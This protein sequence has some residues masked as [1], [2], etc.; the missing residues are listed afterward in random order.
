MAVQNKGE[1]KMK[2]RIISASVAIVLLIITLIFRAS[3]L[4]DIVIGLLSLIASYEILN[5]TNAKNSMPFSIL[6]MIYAFF[7]AFTVRGGFGISF[8]V[9]T[10]IYGILFCGCVLYSFEKI[11]VTTLFTAFAFI[12]SVIFAFTRLIA[13][14]DAKFGMFYFIFIAFCAWG[15]DTGAYFVGCAIGR[16]KLAPVISPKKTIEGLVGGIALNLILCVIYAL[17]YSASVKDVN[18]VSILGLMPVAII[19]SLVSVLGDLFASAVKRFYKIK[20]YGN[21]MPGHGGVLDRFDSI[22]MV[23]VYMTAVMQ[24]F[25]LVK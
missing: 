10:I 7:A 3:I 19:G 22:L 23:A 20:D 9:I 12:I 1:F 4:L 6:S 2:T 14:I 24:L 21:I 15:S 18:S 13:I 25:S 17:I 16:H 11:R 5:V 8:A